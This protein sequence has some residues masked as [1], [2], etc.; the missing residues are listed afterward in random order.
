[1]VRKGPHLPWAGMAAALALSGTA[2]A[3]AKP[4][5]VV[6][7][8]L[9]G[10]GVPAGGG[11]R[12]AKQVSEELQGREEVR[13]VPP[14][15]QVASSKGANPADLLAE[16]AK[17][18]AELRLDQAVGSLTAGIQQSLEDPARAD[19]PKVVEAYVQLAAASFRLG[20][21]KAAQAALFEVARLDP[22]YKLGE[23]FPPVFGRELE[24]AKRRAEKAVRAKLVVDGPPGATG[25]IDG[26]DLGMVP[27]DEELAAGKHYVKVQGPRG[28]L[29]GERVE[30]KASPLTVKAVFSNAPI[31]EPKPDGTVD[32]DLGARVV[33]Y[34]KA[35]GADLVLVGMIYRSSEHQLTAAPALYSVAAQGFRVLTPATVDRELLTSNVEAF[36]VADEVL[37]AVSAFGPS[38]A[39]PFTLAGKQVKVAAAVPKAEDKVDVTARKPPPRDVLLPRAPLV[40]APTKEPVKP[41]EP[42]P[43]PIVAAQSGGVRWYWWVIGGVAVAAAAGGAVYGVTQ[44]TSPVTGTVSASW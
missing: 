42:A 2:W 24:K 28:E 34:A 18:L 1:M 38:A 16:G 8:F 31:A 40:E 21:D 43:P 37:G 35:A 26:K 27:V 39:L 30:V 33:A 14:L 9:A 15:A 17:H 19:F 25:F 23:R 7:P 41:L 32:A 36:R 20:D 10:E 29:F 22:S 5:I 3:A 44:A 4:A 13:V 11:A 12:F 6:A